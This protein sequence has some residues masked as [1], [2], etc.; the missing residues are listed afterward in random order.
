MLIA[1]VRCNVTYITFIIASFK[2]WKMLV[3]MDI[4]MLSFDMY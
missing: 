4:Y 1:D 3:F 2:I